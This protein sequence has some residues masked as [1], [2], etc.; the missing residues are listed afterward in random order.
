MAAA[1]RG[2]ANVAGG[3][4][5]SGPVADVSTAVGAAVAVLKEIEARK[6]TIADAAGF[7]NAVQQILVDLG[8]EPGIVF[9]A[10][11]LLEAIAPAF[12]SA[13]RSGVITGGYPDIV[14]QENDS[15]FKNR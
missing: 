7:A 15:N 12:I 14:G 5:S 13:W 2:V 11:K 6:L 9:E 8:I 4:D 3:A 1:L 10:S